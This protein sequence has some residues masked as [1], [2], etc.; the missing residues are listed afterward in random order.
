[1]EKINGKPVL[2]WVVTVELYVQGTFLST[3]SLERH[4]TAD[5]DTYYYQPLVS[6]QVLR[7]WRENRIFLFF[8]LWSVSQAKV[9]IMTQM[10]KWS[11]KQWVLIMLH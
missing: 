3:V 4:K 1:M 11:R 9:F 2:K 6:V 10:Q 8:L 7:S 5:Q